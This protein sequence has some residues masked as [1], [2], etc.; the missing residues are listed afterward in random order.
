[1]GLD[2]IRV[3]AKGFNKRWDGQ[4]IALA[5]PDMFSPDEAWDEQ[6]VLFEVHPGYALTEG[7]EL[8]VQIGNASLVAFRA[9]EPVATAGN[10]PENVMTAVRRAP[11]YVL[12]RV[13][14]YSSVS[15]TADLAFRL[16]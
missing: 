2:F 11:G 7:E 13:V 8:V 12:S 3:K 15:Q 4:R 16:S 5:T 6:L 14:R 9:H 10:P 1:M